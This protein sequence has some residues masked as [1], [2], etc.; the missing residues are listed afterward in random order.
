VIVPDRAER[1]LL[2]INL[3]PAGIVYLGGEKIYSN[4]SQLKI[5][6]PNQL[7]SFWNKILKRDNNLIMF[8]NDT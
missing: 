6:N 3:I 7:L 2:Q 1:Q 5:T 4:S 8:I